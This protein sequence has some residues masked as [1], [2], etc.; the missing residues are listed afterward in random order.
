MSIRIAEQTPDVETY[1]HLRTASGLSGYETQAAEIGLKNSLYCVMV[2]DGET[3]IGL[4][5]LIGD[6]V[7]LSR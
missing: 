5:R 3:P 4:G 2:F 1:L 7:V 6:G